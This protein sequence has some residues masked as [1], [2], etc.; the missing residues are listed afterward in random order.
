MASSASGDRLP[1]I[2]QIQAKYGVPSLTTVRQAQQI[3]TAKGLLE[4]RRG[5]GVLVAATS[6]P[7]A[8][9][10]LLSRL[11]DAARHWTGPSPNSSEPAR[12]DGEL[13]RHLLNHRRRAGQPDTTAGVLAGLETAV[14]AP[15]HCRTACH[16]PPAWPSCSRR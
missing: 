7:P 9:E 1:P 15:H 5:V 13:P 4:P 8:A 10:T 6:A 2:H 16:R 12:T 11:K 3:L 14:P